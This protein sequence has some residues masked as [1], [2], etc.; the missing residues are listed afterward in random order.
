MVG[1]KEGEVNVGVERGVEGEA[2]GQVGTR[3]VKMFS[4]SKVMK[5]KIVRDTVH[6]ILV[7]KLLHTIGILYLDHHS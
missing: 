1:G 5:L 3:S 2:A 6:K 4:P 7:D